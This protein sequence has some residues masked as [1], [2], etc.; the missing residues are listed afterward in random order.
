M[1]VAQVVGPLSCP[2]SRDAEGLPMYR[3]LTSPWIPELA[4][5]RR[6]SLP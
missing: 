1:R 6:E 2:D 4:G 5:T 3:A